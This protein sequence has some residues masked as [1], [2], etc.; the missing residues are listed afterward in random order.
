MIS[1][2]P[3]ESFG[4]NHKEYFKKSLSELCPKDS[5]GVALWEIKASD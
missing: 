1:P 4:Q 5:F 3:K 2:T